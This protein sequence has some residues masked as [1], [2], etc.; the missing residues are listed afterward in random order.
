MCFVFHFRTKSQR[1]MGS[2]IVAPFTARS[3]RAAD[4]TPVGSRRGGFPSPFKRL[5]ISA[6]RPGRAILSAT[7]GSS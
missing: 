5:L 7:R 4:S 6:M 1:F 2:V 3:E